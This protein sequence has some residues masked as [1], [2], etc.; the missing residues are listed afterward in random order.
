MFLDLP[1]RSWFYRENSL[2]QPKEYALMASVGY[3]PILCANQLPRE[4]RHY[5]KDSVEAPSTDIQTKEIRAM[6]CKIIPSP[7]KQQNSVHENIDPQR[8]QALLDSFDYCAYFPVGK[9]LRTPVRAS[10]MQSHPNNKQK[11]NG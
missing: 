1:V 10:V 7:K 2:L 5:P 9:P 11:D 4:P 6:D 8:L 3:K